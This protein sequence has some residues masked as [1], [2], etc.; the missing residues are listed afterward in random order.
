M[1]SPLLRI[2]VRVPD[3]ARV[4]IPGERYPNSKND[5]VVRELEAAGLHP[6]EVVVR[7]RRGLSRARL[8]LRFTLH[9]PRACSVVMALITRGRHLSLVEA[10][11]VVTYVLFRQLLADTPALV[12]VVLSDTSPDRTAL[13]AAAES[14]EREVIYWQDDYHHDFPLP[15]A[16]TWA[17]VLNPTGRQAVQSTSKAQVF[18]RP[19]RPR[20]P[21]RLGAAA[22]TVGIAVNASFKGTPPQMQK[23][24]T[25]MAA[26]GVEEV[27]LRLHPTSKLTAADLS[28]PWL[29]LAPRDER[30]EDFASRISVAVVGS[31][32]VQIWLACAGCA[33][34][35]VPGLDAQPWDLY[36]YVR[37][38]VIY[39]VEDLRDL[40]LER[41]TAHYS[42]EAVNAWLDEYTSFVSDLVP[43]SL[44][45]LVSRMPRG[46]DRGNSGR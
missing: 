21:F 18:S 15:F 16:A 23:L 28:A 26:L 5:A 25:V 11:L 12:P 33:V 7:G 34:V 40:S 24:S 45:A 4:F 8:G 14:L 19:P 31:S 42:S 22:D 37:Q 46:A 2:P 6:E 29:V 17:A 1:L 43:P 20:Q 32:A 9:L 39:G 10:E 41:M 27:H 36:G 44:E 35:H 13:W 38:G 3:D 30:L